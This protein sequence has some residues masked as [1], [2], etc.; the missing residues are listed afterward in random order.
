[1]KIEGTGR[2]VKL[3]DAKANVY[4]RTVAE[5]TDRRIKGDFTFTDYCTNLSD[6]NR[7]LIGLALR[8]LQTEVGDSLKTADTFIVSGGS[9]SRRDDFTSVS[10]LDF[11]VIPSS[12]KSIKDALELQR[13]LDLAIKHFKENPFSFNTDLRGVYDF[14]IPPI[15]Y[16]DTLLVHEVEAG[17]GDIVIEGLMD[18][19]TAHRFIRD[20]NYIYGDASGYSDLK[21]RCNPVLFPF[22]REEA[23][24]KGVKLFK[25]LIDDASEILKKCK[26][27]RLTEIDNIKDNPK[28]LFLLFK[29]ILSAKYNITNTLSFYETTKRTTL[30]D[31][32]KKSLNKAYE[33]FLSFYEWYA[34]SISK[35]SRHRDMVNKLPTV[36]SEEVNK[37]FARAVEII[38]K[39]LE[40]SLHLL[41][42]QGH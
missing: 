30:S 3:F 15:Q 27:K 31:D 32:D 4:K 22:K 12:E 16:D 21:A 34:L 35:N 20:F 18:Q 11:C 28:R 19:C 17:L 25:Q 23:N 29:Y 13:L 24:P 26:N 37:S 14:S 41:E 38:E 42:A 8:D 1:M 2:K 5:I 10:D 40:S 39:E 36:T 6:V 7:T 9:T 33:D